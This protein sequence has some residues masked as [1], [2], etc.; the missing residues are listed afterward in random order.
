MRVAQPG[1]TCLAAVG[2]LRR[3]AQCAASGAPHT[4]HRAPRA[5]TLVEALAVVALMGIVLPGVMYGI[6]TST[7]AAGVVKQ[8]AAAAEIAANKLNEII[9]AQE[10]QSG[11]LSGDAVQDQTTYHWA[12]AVNNW[13]NQ[14]NI[15]Q[16]DI[17]V[18]WKGQGRPRSV[19]M[20]TLIYQS[21]GSQ[22]AGG[23][24]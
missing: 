7:S 24:S 4:R 19:K 9:L 1:C 18:T 15:E 23:G 20:S 8:R 5:F 10:W 22:Q 17:E 11:A 13:Q 16:I 12:A 3:T 2:S 14:T 6:A 21:P